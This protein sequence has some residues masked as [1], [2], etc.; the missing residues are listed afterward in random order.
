[1]EEQLKEREVQI[2]NTYQ[3]IIAKERQA[4]GRVEIKNAEL[5]TEVEDLKAYIK[6]VI[7]EMEEKEN[8]M[9]ISSKASSELSKK[10]KRL[11]RTI[12]SA[13]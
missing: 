3:A 10:L 4:K 7:E 6:R 12:A 13:K 5:E 11:N 2:E 8:R 1:M 9:Q